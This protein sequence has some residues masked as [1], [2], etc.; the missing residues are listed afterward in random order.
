MTNKYISKNIL[1]NLIKC[2]CVLY[3][4]SISKYGDIY[5]PVFYVKFANVSKIDTFILLAYIWACC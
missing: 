1:E 3:V 4:N 2:V 5:Y